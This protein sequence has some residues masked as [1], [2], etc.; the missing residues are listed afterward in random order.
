V[1]CEEC[2]DDVSAPLGLLPEQII[3]TIAKPTGAGLIDQ[4]G[5]PHLLEARTLIGRTL[6]GGT[7][8][9]IVEA[10]IS[11]HHAHISEERDGSWQVRD[12]GSSNG[13]YLNE[14]PITGPVPIAHGDRI[15]I[16]QVDFYFVKDAG[17]LPAVDVDPAITTSIHPRASAL[18]NL[19]ELDDATTEEPAARL[20]DFVERE[21]TDV[22]LP[23]VRIALAEPTGG[24][25]GLLE[26]EGLQLQLTPIQ[27]ELVHVLKKRMEAEAH[28]PAQ[29]RGF[30]RS[31]ELLGELSWDTK[32]PGEAHVKQLVRRIRR[33][34]IKA[35]IGDLVESR[36]RFGYRLRV[37]PG[38]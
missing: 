3:A 29:V 11:R 18:R 6:D 33:A 4:W 13:T 8:I 21:D 16:G 30:V 28:Q 2:R 10:S 38:T 1:L 34:L 23:E 36:H 12:M 20:A 9:Q 25:G 19:P 32:E 24:G 17:A 31:S 26:V 37:V 5:R 35:G 27:L 7:G 15:G 14:R 22:G